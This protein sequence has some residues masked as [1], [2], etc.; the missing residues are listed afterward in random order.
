M[1]VANSESTVLGQSLRLQEGREKITGRARYTHDLK[2]PGMLHARLVPS[3]YAHANLRGIDA[4]AALA[5]EG[6]VAVLTAEDMPDI[7]PSSRYLLLLAR[8][9]VIFAGQP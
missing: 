6:V 1:S 2:L 3:L 5:R 4:S 8:D 7:E 9:R